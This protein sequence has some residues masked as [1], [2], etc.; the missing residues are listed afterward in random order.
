MNPAQIINF[1]NEYDYNYGKNKLDKRSRKRLRK[2][3]QGNNI[4]I[5]LNEVNPITL[6]QE[7]AF[8]SYYQGQN[9]LLH[10]VAGTGKT[11]ISLYLGL[12][13]ILHNIDDK[14]KIVLVR[15]VVPT[16]DMGFLPGNAK[17]KSKIYESPYYS[18]CTDLFGRGDAYDVLKNKNIVEFISTSYVR[19][20]T[21][22]DSIVIVDECQ[23][24]TFHELD[25]II[26]RLGRNSRLIL[27][28]DFRQ[29]DLWRE[30]EKRG[31]VNFMK[32]LRSMSSFDQIEFEKEDIVRSTLVKEYILSKLS[33]GIYT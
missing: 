1:N 21:L 11:F 32:V 30:T 18:I 17:E 26:T 23:N 13:D 4:S 28:G 24:L 3:K 6:N 27:C 2:L 16:R 10:G 14:E 19:G 15:S 29:T 12:K 33:N 9:L 31:I 8:N 20:I 7:L 22:N 5:H 25:S